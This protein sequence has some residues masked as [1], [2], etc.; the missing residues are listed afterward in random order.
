MKKKKEVVELG[1]QVFNRDAAKVKKTS[2]RRFEV[3]NS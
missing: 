3:S 2:L 1:Q